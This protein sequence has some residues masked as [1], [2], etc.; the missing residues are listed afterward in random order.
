MDKID[1]AR[2]GQGFVQL[3]DDSA[4]QVRQAIEQ[5]STVTATEGNQVT[6]EGR[7]I[8]EGHGFALQVNCFDIFECPRGYLLHVYMDN[9]PN[10]AVTGKT[11]A[12]LLNRAPDSRVVKRARGLLVQKNLRV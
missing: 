9:S 6:F 2:H 11:L 3:E 8:I 1:A 10:W 5:V 7:R 12:E 4:A